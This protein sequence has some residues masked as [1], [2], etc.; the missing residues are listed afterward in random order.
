MQIQNE[1]VRAFNALGL[2]VYARMDFIMDEEGSIYCLEANTLPGMTSHSLVPKAA[3][4]MG[5]PFPE[6]CDRML[7][8]ASFDGK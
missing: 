7:S 6:L 5:L 8:S 3:E 1:A 4:R 2:E